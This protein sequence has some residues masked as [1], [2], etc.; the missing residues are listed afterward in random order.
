MF[1]LPMTIAK[2]FEFLFQMCNF[3]IRQVLKSYQARSGSR[4]TAE[5]LIQFELRRFRITVLGVLYQEY[6]EEGNH[7]RNGVDC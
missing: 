7:S 6:H 5:Q 1:S 2:L 3:F 4:N